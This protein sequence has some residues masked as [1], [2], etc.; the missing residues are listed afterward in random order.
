MRKGSSSIMWYIITVLCFQAISIVLV[1][2]QS[3]SILEITNRWGDKYQSLAA[4]KY[5]QLG[6][7]Q[8]GNR[9][10]PRRSMKRAQD[11]PHLA[12]TLFNENTLKSNP[13]DHCV[14]EQLMWM[15]NKIIIG[16]MCFFFHSSI[17]NKIVTLFLNLLDYYDLSNSFSTSWIKFPLNQAKDI[18]DLSNQDE[19]ENKLQLTKIDN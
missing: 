19:H 3:T 9:P 18:Y 13:T 12:W 14:S 15:T 5:W 11:I 7:T 10:L 1:W 16:N 17:S 2:H 4:E 8:A 6:T